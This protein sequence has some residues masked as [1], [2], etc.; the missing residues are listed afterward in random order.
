[1]KYSLVRKK[2][3]FNHKSIQFFLYVYV[4]DA[5]FK[6]RLNLGYKEE[7]DINLN[8]IVGN[9]DPD[10]VFRGY[11]SKKMVKNASHHFQQKFKK[12]ATG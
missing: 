12:N 9:R 5:Q 6:T 1:M 8:K 10:W 3:G 2:K 11:F 4:S 7:C